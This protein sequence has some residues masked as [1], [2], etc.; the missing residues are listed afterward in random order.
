[1]KALEEVWRSLRV[2]GHDARELLRVITTLEQD[3]LWAEAVALHR[4]FMEWFERQRA[5]LPPAQQA[6]HGFKVVRRTHGVTLRW[7]RFEFYG[8]SGKPRCIHRSVARGS[9]PKY[10]L[11]RFGG[12]SPLE[13]EMITSIEDRAGPLREWSDQLVALGKVVG[14]YRAGGREE[15]GAHGVTD[16]DR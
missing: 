11:A 8:G 2:G 3:E 12:A 7:V 15:T 4:E 14:R 1:M 6:K 5:G 10:A 13:R 9:T 16:D